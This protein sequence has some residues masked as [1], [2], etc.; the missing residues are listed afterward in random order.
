RSLITTLWSV[1]DAATAQLMTY[2][3]EGLSENLPKDIALQQAKLRLLEEENMPP[4]YWA[5][6]IAVGDMRPI[7]ESFWM[8]GVMGG[9]VILLLMGMF[10]YRRRSLR[11]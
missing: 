3:Y 8:Y 10:F 4:F 9:L 11:R 7:R 5:A 1:D 2:F 6:P